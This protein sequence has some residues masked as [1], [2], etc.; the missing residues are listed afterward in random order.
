MDPRVPMDLPVVEEQS[1]HAD[2]RRWL[3]QLPSLLDVA[4]HR[5]DLDLGD[6][7]RSGSAAWA[8]PV[9]RRSDG[10]DAV[11]KVTLPH[12]EARH[13]GAGLR[14]W[15]GDGAV[16]LIDEDEETF[17]LL[18]ERCRPG[19]QINDDPAS[20]EDRLASAAEVLK[21]LWARPVGSAAPFETVADVCR[22][23]ATGVRQRMAD[24]GPP[25]D[26]ALV[27][28]GATLLETLPPTAN[29]SV[30]VHGDFNPTNILSAER[31]P[32]LAIDPKPMIG[33][34]CYDVVPLVAQLGEPSDG[35]PRPDALRRHF[36][37]VSEIVDES[38]E[39]MCAW[40]A[41]RSVEA[42][43]WYVS[44]E[45]LDEARDTMLWARAFAD[46]SQ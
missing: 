20:T 43:L 33:D 6:P 19:D 25:L 31:E 40:A 21:R 10:L 1:R 24:L 14:H 17:T 42:A 45:R 11:L 7:F 28:L 44:L 8:A 15:D 39:R 18:I 46:L 34:P 9:V 36:A 2:G 4:V 29:R 26:P 22:E 30:L 13:E 38:P 12:R 3:A 16:T 27:E 32:W 5:W 35:R 37:L 23:W 41:A